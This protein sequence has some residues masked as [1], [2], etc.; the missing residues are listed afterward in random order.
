MALDA[1]KY[2]R[3]G[4]AIPR[5]GAWDVRFFY[6]R[7]RRNDEVCRACPV[8]AFGIDNYEAV[9]THAGLSYVSRLKA[10]S[11]VAPHRGPTNLRL[12]CHLGIQVPAGDCGLHVGDE[13]QRWT[14]GRCLV[15]NDYSEHEAWNNRKKTELY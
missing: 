11:R 7:G 14:E 15:F 9:R 3:E 8:T 1:K 2:Q 12:R 13:V 5:T 10:G 6:D 4:E